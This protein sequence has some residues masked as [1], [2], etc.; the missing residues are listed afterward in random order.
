MSKE[1]NPK[2]VLPEYDFLGSIYKNTSKSEL[3][4]ALNSIQNQTIKPKNIILVID[5]YISKEVD[6]LVNEYM[7]S[8][9]IIKVPL[10]ENC[11]LGIALRIGLK[12]VNLT[13]F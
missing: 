7:Q 3:S 11:G 4:A 9:P 6:F 1:N 13:L 10:K 5:G 2:L 8:L 12:S